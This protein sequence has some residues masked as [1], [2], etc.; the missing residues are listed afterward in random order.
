M[1]GGKVSHAHHFLPL[2][3]KIYFL[4]TSLATYCVP[5]MYHTFGNQCSIYC[6]Y[7]KTL[8]HLF[9]WQ[10]I[11]C[12]IVDAFIENNKKGVQKK[13]KKSIERREW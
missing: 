10:Q 2:E 12:C 11:S 8:E 7:D 3:R 13:Y 4:S 1:D 5:F 6:S 9:M